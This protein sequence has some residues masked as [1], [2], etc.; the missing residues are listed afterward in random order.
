MGNDYTIIST[1]YPSTPQQIRPLSSQRS[2]NSLNRL[3]NEKKSIHEDHDSFSRSPNMKKIT[4]MM[5]FDDSILSLENEPTDNV[6]NTPGLPDLPSPKIGDNLKI[7]SPNKRFSPR[8]LFDTSLTKS[9]PSKNSSSFL[10]SDYNRLERQYTDLSIKYNN[11]NLDFQAL[12]QD[13]LSKTTINKQDSETIKNLQSYIKTIQEEFNHD[14]ILLTQNAKL[15]E[16]IIF[17]LNLKIK[18]IS[19]DKR[20]NENFNNDD[21]LQLSSKYDKLSR[22]YNILKS[23]YE[24]EQSSK[25]FLIDQIDNLN[26]EIEC[27]KSSNTDLNLHDFAHENSVIQYSVEHTMNQL[28]DDDDDVDHTNC[29]DEIL[30]DESSNL[31]DSFQQFNSTFEFPSKSSTKLKHQSLPTQLK[32]DFILSPLK[33]ATNMLYFEPEQDLTNHKGSNKV[34]RYSTGHSRYNSHDI[35]PIQV[36]FEP[37]ETRSTSVPEYQLQKTIEEDEIEQES[38]H[39]HEQEPNERT[40]AFNKLNGQSMPIPQ[41]NASSTTFRNSIIGDDIRNSIISTSSKRSSLNEEPMKKQDIMKLKFE[42]QSLKLQNEKLLSYIG[43]ELQKQNLNI[44][45]LTKTIEYS[46][47]KLIERSREELI[48]KKRVLRS[49]SI[50]SILSKNY[51]NGFPNNSNNI[52]MTSS[53]ILLGNGILNHFEFNEED[54]YGFLNENDQF[55]N[56]IFSRGLQKYFHDNIDEDDYQSKKCLKNH[57][58]L[59]N[60]RYSY[61]V[62]DDN[63]IEESQESSFDQVSSDEELGLIGQFKHMILGSN[64]KKYMKNEE[65]VDDRLKYKFVAITLGIMIIGLK[66]SH[67][68]IQQQLS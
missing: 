19:D 4:N 48:H 49:V 64:K 40:H 42:L 50:N 54:D 1:T 13:L 63:I 32:D 60:I 39:E 43:F 30:Q 9:S 58:S 52:P 65:L 20:S 61:G 55:P 26:Q 10:Q 16:K 6:L 21:F 47:S 62:D 33:L 12:Q 8:K 44:A 28:T 41:S 23:N 66:F 35:I 51:K 59:K 46:D 34:K 3:D 25:K 22:E 24:L 38:E 36:E 18:K 5:K 53:S 27:L 56:R 37:V 67:Q 57:K 7:K 17:D 14:K 29:D 11:L 15:N 68:N 31:P 2:M 45:E